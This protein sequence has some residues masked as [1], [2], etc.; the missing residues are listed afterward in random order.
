MRH[1]SSFRYIPLG[2]RTGVR[3]PSWNIASLDLL[4]SSL[5]KRVKTLRAYSRLFLT[6]FLQKQTLRAYMRH[7]SSFRYIPLGLRT[8]VRAPSW[9]IASLDL[10]A[11]SLLKRVNTSQAFS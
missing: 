6:H 3:A 2:L 11:S 4:A 10:L 8:G 1:I 7:I 5:L 9:K